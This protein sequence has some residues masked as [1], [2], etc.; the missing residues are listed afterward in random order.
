M[1]IECNATGIGV[2]V[3]QGTAF[4]C[5]DSNNNNYIALRHTLFRGS[6]KPEVVCNNG[7]IIARA[8]GVFKN[9]YIP[10]LV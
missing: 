10:N 8:I 2:T 4:Q 5:D 3:W 1:V 9:I 6:Q 7:A